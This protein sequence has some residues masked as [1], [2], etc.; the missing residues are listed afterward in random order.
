MLFAYREVL[1]EATGFSPFELLYG[2]TLRGPMQILKELWTSEIEVPE[3]KTSYQ[4]VI[5]LQNRLEATTKL[6]QEELRKNPIKN[7]QLYDRKAKRREFKV[8]DKV[9]VLLLTSSNKLLMH[10]R[11]PYT[12][13]KQVAGNNYKINTKNKFKMYHANMLKPYFAR[14]EDSSKDNN[15]ED[16]M[17]VVTATAT[18]EEEPSV[19]EECLLTF[20]QLAQSESVDDVKISQGLTQSQKEGIRNVLQKYNEVFSDLPGRTNVIQHHIKLTEEE[21]V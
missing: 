15:P 13:T 11:G 18:I 20:E 7:K 4:Y 8:G 5:D 19:E 17:P 12:I 21:P 14:S 2:R 1:Q 9:L 3:T 16:N 10:W 6:A